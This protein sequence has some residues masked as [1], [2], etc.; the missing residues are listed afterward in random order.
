MMCMMLARS[1]VL[2]FSALAARSL[3]SGHSL[4]WQEPEAQCL[5][6]KLITI[7]R[8]GNP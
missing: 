5:Q 8:K 2:L 3:R 6:Q 4:R 7:W 1:I